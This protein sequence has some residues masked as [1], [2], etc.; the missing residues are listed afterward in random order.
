MIEHADHPIAVWA[1]DLLWPCALPSAPIIDARGVTAL[2]VWAHAWLRQHP[3]VIVIA[4]ESL[5]ARLCGLGI[6]CHTSLDDLRG[7][8]VSA[9]ERS[10]L[11]GDT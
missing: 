1:G 9:S 10:M 3:D 8:G 4:D 7:N 6:R 11:W 5:H 2:G